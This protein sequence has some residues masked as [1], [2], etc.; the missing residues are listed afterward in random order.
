MI[1][2]RKKMMGVVADG[3]QEGE[4]EVESLD[5]EEDIPWT[6]GLE[7]GAAKSGRSSC[8]LQLSVSNTL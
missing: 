1:E 4:V 5:A 6:E 2:Q 7:G 8:A 3:I